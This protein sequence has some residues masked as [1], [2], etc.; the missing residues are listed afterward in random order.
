MQEVKTISWKVLRAGQVRP[1]AD[2]VYEYEIESNIHENQVKEFCFTFLKRVNSKNKGNNFSG[3]C[4][5]PYG[6]SAYYQFTKVEE[7]KY[8]Y[9]VCNPY[10]G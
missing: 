5:F 10:T 9:T 8:L 1:Y 2:S 7:G 4:S 6:L 3:N